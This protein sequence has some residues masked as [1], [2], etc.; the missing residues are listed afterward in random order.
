MGSM[1]SKGWGFRS[2]DVG[3]TINV[4]TALVLFPFL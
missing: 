2:A 3:V 4:N 1:S